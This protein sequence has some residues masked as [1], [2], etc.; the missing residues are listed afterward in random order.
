[1]NTINK[2]KILAVSAILGL[3]LPSCNDWLD[4]EM[5]DQVL[6]NTLFSNYEGYLTALNGIYLSMNDVYGGTLSTA[7]LDVMAQYY[8]VTNDN[9][10]ALKLYATYN[11]TDVKFEGYNSSLWNQ[12]YTLLANINV[13]IERT[14]KDT[15]LTE[16]QLAI[17]RGEALALRAFVHFDLLR[18][19]GPIYSDAP[20][21]ESIPYQNSTSREVQPILPAD[22]A[23]ELIIND[24]RSAES[25]L[26]D[27]DPIIT[28]GVRNEEIDENGLMSY[29]LAFRQIRMN[30]YAVEALLARAYLWKGD[31]ATAYDIAV[32]NILKKISSESLEVFPWT[33][34][35]KLTVE[36]KPDFLFSS[37]VFFS[38]YNSRRYTDVYNAYFAPTLAAKKSRLTFFGDGMTGSTS[39]IPSFYDDDNDMRRLMW[40]VVEPT[41]EEKNNASAWDPAKNS[42]AL[43]KYRDF[44][45]NAS[46]VS[47]RDNYRYMIPLI[48]LSEIYLIAAE[49]ATTEAEGRSL[50]NTVRNHRDCRS[51]ADNEDFNKA[52]TYEMA[53]EVIGEGQLFFFY[54][55]RGEEQLIGSKGDWYDNYSSTIAMLKGNYVWP[56][57]KSEADKRVSIN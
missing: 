34:R 28:E 31:K 5:E 29:D 17:I 46:F 3:G 56:I 50:L 39:K 8:Y 30:Y 42:L 47:G 45:Q 36:N 49:C 35:D 33:S 11:Y 43:L 2:V 52:L 55:R 15:P 22:Q 27:Y 32:N 41:E 13:I 12:C 53:R 38:L 16:R 24:L 20:T 14:E 9:D 37:E 7:G 6:E 26:R 10:H 18:L 48:R 54:K 51:L 25:L 40:N 57:P 21:A 1:M 4:V 44:T 23:L 19:Y